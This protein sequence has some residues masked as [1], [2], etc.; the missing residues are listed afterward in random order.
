MVILTRGSFST[1]RFKYRSSSAARRHIF[2]MS[3]VLKDAAIAS[4]NS[5]MR[6][7]G[8]VAI[9]IP[10]HGGVTINTD[11][12]TDQ[13]DWYALI[14]KWRGFPGGIAK[15]MQSKNFPVHGKTR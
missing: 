13:V 7:L 6:L 11:V 8:M 4:A 9:S 10:Q 15:V 14:V 2:S 3:L 12:C 5:G 1:A